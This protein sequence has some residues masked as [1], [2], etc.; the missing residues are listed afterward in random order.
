M[1]ESY[2]FDGAY[3]IINLARDIVELQGMQLTDIYFDKGELISEREIRALRLFAGGETV[4]VHLDYEEIEEFSTRKNTVPVCMKIIRA[5]DRLYEETA[6][7]KDHFT[8]PAQFH[9]HA[10]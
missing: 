8:L 5:V 10:L 1:R 9:I 7:D 2:L 4:T 6:S 3:R